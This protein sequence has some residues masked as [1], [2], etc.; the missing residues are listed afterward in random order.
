MGRL[1]RRL[2]KPADMDAAT[3]G[4]AQALPPSR[5]GQR[6]PDNYLE[7]IAKYFPGEVLAFFIVINAILQQAMRAGG[8]TATMAGLPVMTVAQGALAFAVVL[9]PLFVWYVREEGDAWLTNAVVSTLL[10]PFWAYALGAAAF[11]TMWDGNLAAI[12]LVTATV[13]SGLV[14]PARKASADPLPSAVPTR[15]ERPQLDLVPPTPAAMA[16]PEQTIALR[17]ERPQLDLIT[18]TPA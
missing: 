16:A 7:R 13:L 3:A 18:P 15:T 14:L 10:F 12:L 11:S 17:T 2:S 6:A 1:V 9:V 4:A 5:A 8:E